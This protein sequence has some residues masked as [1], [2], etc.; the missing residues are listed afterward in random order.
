MPVA[1]QVVAIFAGD[2]GY[3]GRPAGS[4]DV[5]RF[6]TELL[7]FLRA[8]KPEIFETHRQG[9]EAHRRRSRTDLNAAIEAFKHHVR[10]RGVR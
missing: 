8:S 5:V 2:E 1:E 3:P 4:D 6:R 9:E 7:D 10:R